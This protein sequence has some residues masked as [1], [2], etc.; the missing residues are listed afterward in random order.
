M[1]APRHDCFRK[2]DVRIAAIIPLYNGAAYITQAI[3]SVLNQTLPPGEIIVI[4][5]GSTDDGAAIV[6]KIAQEHPIKILRK[7]NGGQASA[8]NFGIANSNCDL[9]ALLDQ[10]DVWY[11]NHLEVLV[12]PFLR[13]RAIELGW[14]YS[15]LDEIDQQGRLTARSALRFQDN[16]QHPKRDI[17]GCLS[18]DMF[19]L[20]SAS[21][22]S[23]RAFDAVG[24]FDERLRGY[25][26]DDLFVRMFSAG[27]DNIYLNQGLSQWRVFPG[28]ASFSGRMATSRMLYFRKLLAEFPNEPGQGRIWDRDVLIPRFFPQ[29]VG[30]FTSALRRKDPE[31]IR[32]SLEDLQFAARYHNRTVRTIMN[33]LL[34]VFRV[35]AFAR[36]ALM[37]QSAI[38]P[39]TRRIL[40]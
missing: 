20:P 35:P 37:A 21:M 34:P 1:V 7:P 22:I 38:R 11:C 2:E 36:A 32:T 4:D 14:V 24:G 13:P 10:D 9:I 3:E 28:S 39:L 16:I 30:E 26:D 40:G 5:D 29:F 19:V 17:H 15:N 8:R 12:R 33:V 27:Y 18:T 23:R 6:E 31:L 25:E